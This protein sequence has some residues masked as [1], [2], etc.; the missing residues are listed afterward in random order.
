MKIG[1]NKIDNEWYY[2]QNNGI[3]AVNTIM[4]GYAIGDKGKL[5]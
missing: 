4:E 3:L 2:F 5:I 1:W